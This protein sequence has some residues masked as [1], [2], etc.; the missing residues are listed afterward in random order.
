M[1]LTPPSCVSMVCV[2]VQ[3]AGVSQHSPIVRT[4]QLSYSLLTYVCKSNRQN[5]LYAARW[6]ETFIQQA[7]STDERNDLL[8]EAML[9]TLLTDNRELL[10]HA[11]SPVTISRFVKIIRMQSEND[12]YLKLL[13]ALCTCRGDAVACNQDAIT[14]V[15]LKE[16]AVREQ[17]LVFVRVAEFGNGLEVS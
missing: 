5:Q 16:A 10:E 6:I 12:R 1:P 13:S 4:C 15:L 17:L 2:G 8:A 14:D 7:C 3:L 9:T 11:I